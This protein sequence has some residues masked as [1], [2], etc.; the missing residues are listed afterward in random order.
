LKRI[1]LIL[2]LLLPTLIISAQRPDAP[3]YATRG[4]YVVGTRNDTIEDA[5]RP[6][7]LTLWYPALNPDGAEVSATY[8]YSGF[9]FS[10]SALRDAPADDS[11]APYPL[12]LFSHGSGGFRFQSLFLVEHL[13]SH[14]FVV[15]AVDHPTNT[16]AESLNE[17]A[18][19]EALAANY[20]YRP[21]DLQRVVEYLAASDD[22]IANI[23]DTEQ[24]ALSGHSFGG[25]TA[26]AAAGGQLNF[27]QLAQ[28]C[29]DPNILDALKDSVCFLQADETDVADVF[30]YDEAPQGAW[31]AV[32]IEGVDAL[33]ALAPWNGPIFDTDSVSEINV[34][35]LFIVGSEDAVTQPQRDAYAI[36]QRMTNAQRSLV[37]LE[38]GGHF[39]FVDQ[40]SDIVV[41][42]GFFTSCSDQV[43]DM[44]RAH[45]LINHYT[46]AFLLAT[47][48]DDPGAAAIVQSNESAFRGVNQLYEEV[49]QVSQLVPE[50]INR[51]PHDADAFTQ[52]LLLH[53]GEFYES[54]G[55]YGESDLRRVEPTTGEVLQITDVPE[56][57]FAEGLALVDDRLIQITWRENTA[58]VYDRETFEQIDSYT[59][60]GE[61]WGLCYDG[62][63]LYM[64]DGSPTITRRDP[65]TFEVL[66]TFSVTVEGTPVEE[67]NELECV[68]DQIYANVWQSDLIVR[69]DTSNGIV[70]AVINAAGLLTPEERATA[71]NIDVLNGIAYNT[72]DDTFYITGKLWPTLFEVR[73]VEG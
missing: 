56:E 27:D 28:F 35:S 37:V 72:E 45:D 17:S 42:L 8:N 44:Q 52:G 31:P 2:V 54:T 61:G 40:C 30:G 12:V 47:F 29:D 3:E 51:Y 43:W 33:I 55:L 49:S 32:T 1:V 22:P 4:E 65:Q 71:E 18:F 58:F 25:Y 60:E 11:A 20:A 67:L 41:N 64:S 39:L 46:T 53:A 9:N 68:S 13:T 19:D 23:I 14:G 70:N 24:I 26:L 59:Y 21:L 6:L 66:D 57:F 38:N 63:S 7:S 15:A 48:Y 16:L 69:F 73:F 10:G 5:D 62:D 36:Y 34:P 50:V